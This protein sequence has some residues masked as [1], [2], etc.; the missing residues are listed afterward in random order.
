MLYNLLILQTYNKVN[1]MGV[2]VC[3]FNNS[4]NKVETHMQYLVPS[5]Y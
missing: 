4:S 3:S 1:V 5:V 2:F